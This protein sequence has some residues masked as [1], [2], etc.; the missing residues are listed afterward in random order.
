MTI[1]VVLI[2]TCGT[3]EAGGLCQAFRG[4]DFRYCINSG[5]IFFHLPVEVMVLSLVM[6]TFDLR[7]SRLISILAYV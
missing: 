4:S 2:L 5:I 3:L 1:D 7:L 6:L